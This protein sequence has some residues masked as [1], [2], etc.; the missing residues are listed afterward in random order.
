MSVDAADRYFCSASA[1]QSCLHL[2]YE[3]L[4]SAP[5]EVCGRLREFLGL[6]PSEGMLKFAAG[7]VKRQNPSAGERAIP[8]ATEEIAGEA[9]RRLGYWP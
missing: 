5:V 8:S 2:R 9:L 7:E 6:A 1:T 4:L 3:E